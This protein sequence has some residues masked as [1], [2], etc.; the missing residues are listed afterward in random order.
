VPRAA[1]REE[2]L[3]FGAPVVVEVADRHDDPAV[4]DLVLGSA[5]HRAGGV[6]VVVCVEFDPVA[7]YE[8][9]RP[10]EGS[11]HPV[12]L[13]REGGASRRLA[14]HPHVGYEQVDPGVDVAPVDG[15]CVSDRQ[16]Q[17]GQAA[18]DSGAVVAGAMG[19]G[20]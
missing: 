4:F 12:D 9:D 15:Q 18:L 19:A 7:A 16:L 10:S 6:I 1:A 20:K 13:C 14:C 8:V 2:P 3:T 5:V 17:D 11:Q